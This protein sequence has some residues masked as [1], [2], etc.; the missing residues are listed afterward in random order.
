MGK[1]DLLEAGV[2]APPDCLSGYKSTSRENHLGNARGTANPDDSIPHGLNANRYI[3]TIPKV[4]GRCVFRLRYN[5]S[6]SDYWA[7]DAE[8]TPKTNGT[9]NGEEKSPIIQDPYVGVGPNPQSDFMEL[10]VNTN[11]Y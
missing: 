4:E 2:T 6:T 3:W 1:L 11:Q 10:A 9:W 8:G 5:I 7:W